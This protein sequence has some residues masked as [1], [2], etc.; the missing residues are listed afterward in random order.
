M[1]T[2]SN[3]VYT[4]IYIQEQLSSVKSLCPNSRNS[5]RYRFQYIG[6]WINSTTVISVIL[7]SNVSAFLYA[8]PPRFVFFYVFIALF[9][10]LDNLF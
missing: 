4:C 8:D 6:T 3:H 2:L 7:E 9:C 5:D 1:Y 10:T